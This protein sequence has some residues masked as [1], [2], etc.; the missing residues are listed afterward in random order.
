M[1]AHNNPAVPVGVLTTSEGGSE[2]RTVEKESGTLFR[3]DVLS[4]ARGYPHS[5]ILR[6]FSSYFVFIGHVSS[7]HFAMSPFQLPTLARQRDS[8]RQFSTITLTR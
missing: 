6:S 3:T 2:E 1:D 7:S 4:T 5:F 8:C